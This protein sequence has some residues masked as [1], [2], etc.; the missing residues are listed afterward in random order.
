MLDST[1][2]LRKTTNSTSALRKTSGSTSALRKTTEFPLDPLPLSRQALESHYS[3]MRRSHVFMSRSQ[4]QMKWRAKKHAQERAKLAKRLRDYGK[5]FT[6]LGK[7]K[8]EDLLLLQQE[9]A[10]FESKERAFL[11]LLEE[12][13]DAKG[14]TNFWNPLAANRLLERI[15]ALL[16]SRERP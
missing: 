2:A 14:R 8:A 1:S 5:Q 9:I 7:Q 10:A 6:K 11:Q 3:A 15:K 16:H 4:G 13:E 12:I